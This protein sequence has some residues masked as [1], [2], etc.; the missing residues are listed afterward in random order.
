MKL[1][2]NV[3]QKNLTLCSGIQNRWDLEYI[4][5]YSGTQKWSFKQKFTRK[6][7]QN[8]VS[9]SKRIS[10][11]RKRFQQKNSP[12][13]GAVLRILSPTYH[14]LLNK[15]LPRVRTFSDNSDILL[16]KTLKEFFVK[17]SW[18]WGKFCFPGI[19]SPRYVLSL[20]KTFAVLNYKYT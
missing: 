12:K 13:Q 16:G 5:V 15:T 20:I 17:I 3:H 8:R 2:G 14:L 18:I 4:I 1:C 11:F 10:E 6:F 19:S 7:Q 9:A